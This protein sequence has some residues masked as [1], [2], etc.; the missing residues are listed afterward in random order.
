MD[1]IIEPAEP[2]PRLDHA[3]VLLMQ[4]A[5]GLMFIP[6]TRLQETPIE[7]AAKQ[8]TFPGFVVD[9]PVIA[10]LD[11]A[12]ADGEYRQFRLVSEH[13]AD[14]FA[15]KV[16]DWG[17]YGVVLTTDKMTAARTPGWGFKKPN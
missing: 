9:L 4:P 16:V 1:R 8:M 17:K 6:V 11:R 13:G 3:V 15:A 12:K 14:M 7:H 10:A 5:A 2:D